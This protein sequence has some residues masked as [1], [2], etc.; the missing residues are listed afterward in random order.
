MSPDWI[1]PPRL[2][3]AAR[4]PPGVAGAVVGTEAAE[5]RLA[6]QVLQAQRRHLAPADR[7]QV[8]GHEARHHIASA[9]HHAARTMVLQT[10]MR[11]RQQCI[12]P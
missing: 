5:G 7:L 1:C 10:S 8:A 11:I 4:D 9:L 2:G 12:V 3:L 6:E